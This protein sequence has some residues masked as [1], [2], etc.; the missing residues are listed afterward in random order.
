MEKVIFVLESFD[1]DHGVIVCKREALDTSY[2]LIKSEDITQ[3]QMILE[4]LEIF[5]RK[6]YY[7]ESLF[8]HTFYDFAK[9]KL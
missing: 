3:E 5:E 7:F 1:A 8:L 4:L 9:I 2:W 6:W